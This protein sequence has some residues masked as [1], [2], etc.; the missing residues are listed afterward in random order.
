M[1]RE[2]P[3]YDLVITG[4]RVI[5]PASGLDGRAQV[6]VKDGRIAAVAPELAPFDSAR[7][8]DAAG[9]IVCPGL[10]DFHVHVYEWV[11]NFGLPPDQAG[12]H[13]GVTT[14]V[15]QGSAG[16]W[17]VGGFKAH[18]ADRA[19]TDVRAFVSA[20]LAGAQQG[21]MEG[22]VLH[23]PGMMRIEAIE[24]AA[25]D[26]PG[27]MKGIKS[28][29]ESGGFSQWGTEVLE[30]AVEAGN[31]TGLPLYVHTGELFP[32][33]EE[34]RPDPATVLERVVPCLRAGD[35]LA[36]IYSAMPDGI[37][38]P[39]SEIPAIVF[40]AQARGIHFDIGYGVNFSYAIARKMMAAGILPNTIASDVHSDFNAYHD[41]ST[42][43]YSL[44]GAMTRLW[45]L[46]MDL[47]DII[48]R[49][50]LH[51][52][53]ILREE[54]EIGTLAA[55]S[56]AD[57]TVLDRVAG[58]WPMTDSTGEVLDVQERLI[59]ALVIRE[60]REIVPDRQLLRDVWATGLSEAAE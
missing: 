16:A 38:G 39:S 3:N 48:R 36:H 13:A 59:P 56:R 41:D 1:T 52:A 14:I 6:A 47:A 27:L 21:G 23:N 46:G 42:L 45:A 55:G 11:T 7:T 19:E 28:H 43:D 60:G 5:D 33:V 9:R 12:V 25:R 40:E 17:T 8:I 54:D 35:T 20:N 44:C 2:R 26:Y 22:T 58:A 37:M 29:G 18:I 57:I 24:E 31:R 30:M 49:T 53:M 51:P 34:T 10:I 4:G 50:T 32:V 15:D